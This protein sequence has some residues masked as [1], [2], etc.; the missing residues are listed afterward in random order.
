M[1]QQG[2]RTMLRSG[3]QEPRPAGDP[4][5]LGEETRRLSPVL[6]CA[7]RDQGNRGVGCSLLYLPGEEFQASCSKILFRLWLFFVRQRSVAYMM[8]LDS[9]H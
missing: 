9:T 2:T 7:D 3:Q 1:A 4:V 5:I 8:T 6:M